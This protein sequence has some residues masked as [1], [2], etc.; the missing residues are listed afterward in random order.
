M[1]H[2]GAVENEARGVGEGWIRW[3]LEARGSS[4]DFIQSVVRSH[5][6]GYDMA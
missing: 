3:G 1:E 5:Q 6:K 4:W 2:R